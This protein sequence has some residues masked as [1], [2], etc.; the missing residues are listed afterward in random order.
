M[1]RKN[2]VVV[3]GGGL[4]LWDSGLDARAP[5][6]NRSRLSDGDRPCS[7]ALPIAD[8][9]PAVAKLRSNNGVKAGVERLRPRLSSK[10]GQPRACFFSDSTK[11]LPHS[12]K[13]HFTPISLRHA[14]AISSIVATRILGVNPA[15][16]AS[17]RCPADLGLASGHGLYANPSIARVIRRCCDELFTGEHQVFGPP[18]QFEDFVVG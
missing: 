1:I 8:S 17:F 15:R 13:S 12:K 18:N 10:T 4:S 5:V 11:L 2:Y 6:R 3:E 16:F 14:H 9:F 7:R